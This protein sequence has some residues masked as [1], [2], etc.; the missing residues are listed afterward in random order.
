MTSEN[1]NTILSLDTLVIKDLKGHPTKSVYKKPTV[2]DQ[3]PFYN[4]YHP[5]SV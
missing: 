5:Q 2:T 3:Y 1:D 4:L